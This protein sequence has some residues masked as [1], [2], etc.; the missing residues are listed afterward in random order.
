MLNNIKTALK[1]NAL[2]SLLSAATLLSLPQFLAQQFG[3]KSPLPLYIIG[4]GL[5]FFVLSLLYTASRPV[6]NHGQ[7]QSIVIQ[8][9]LWVLA[10]LIILVVQP[11]GLSTVALWAI[12]IV[13]LVVGA[14]GYWQYRLLP[15]TD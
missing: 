8:D 15:S 6:V 11:F 4:A 3:L 9:A 2:F 10:S 12:A 7:V 5:L 13:A 14:L 1:A